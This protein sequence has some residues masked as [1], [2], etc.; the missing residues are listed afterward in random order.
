MKKAH[1]GA[2]DGP[3]GNS[4]FNWTLATISHMEVKFYVLKQN[5]FQSEFVSQ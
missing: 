4:S 2:H 1:T 5:I 3:S